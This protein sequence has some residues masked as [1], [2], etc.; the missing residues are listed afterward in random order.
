MID[1]SI[2]EYSRDKEYIRRNKYCA[3]VRNPFGSY[4]VLGHTD[5]TIKKCLQ[6]CVNNIEID[7]DALK[8]R[9]EDG[10]ISEE[11]RDELEYW[12]ELMI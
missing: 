8:N 10:D 6:E 11:D 4:I 2:K 1:N 12:A 3:M 9:L 7:V 5:S